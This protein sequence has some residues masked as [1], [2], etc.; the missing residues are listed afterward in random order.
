MTVTPKIYVASLSDYNAGVLH[1]KWIEAVQDADEIRAE[2][3]RML[4]ESNAEP[5]EEYAIHDY[6]GFG[7]IKLS[8]YEDIDTVAELAALLDEHGELFGHVYEHADRDTA[9]AKE[10][11]SDGYHGAF[12]SLEAY[13]ENFIDETGGLEKMPENLR[14]YFDY[15][16]YAH[17]LEIGG[18]VFTVEVGGKTHVFDGH[19]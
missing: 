15:E 3:A 12:D 9:R 4:A 1:G 2:I 8:E 6:E 14:C 13:A 16:K 5:A 11:M 7:P 18:D 19:L 17:D 10:L